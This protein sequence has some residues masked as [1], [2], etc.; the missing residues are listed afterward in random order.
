MS[1]PWDR[2]GVTPEDL[3]NWESVANSGDAFVHTAV[4]KS[5]E[6][7]LLLYVQNNRPDL[8]QN[9]QMYLET[10][11]EENSDDLKS[12]SE[13]ESLG[14][15][16]WDDDSASEDDRITVVEVG[17]KADEVGVQSVRTDEDLLVP[18]SC[19]GS[20]V[21]EWID[22]WID[23]VCHEI[24]ESCA[25]KEAQ[26]KM[27]DRFMDTPAAIV[28]TVK[29]VLNISEVTNEFCMFGTPLSSPSNSE[30]WYTNFD[31]NYQ[32]KR[33]TDASN[34]CSAEKQTL[35]PFQTDSRTFT[36]SYNEETQLLDGSSSNCER[37]IAN[38]LPEE[39]QIGF[40][41]DSTPDEIS[42]SFG[43]S[44]QNFKQK[45][46]I[47]TSNFED[48][49][50]KFNNIN[51][52]ESEFKSDESTFNNSSNEY[53]KIE[54]PL[55]VFHDLFTFEN[56]K[57]ENNTDYVPEDS[58]I[59]DSSVSIKTMVL[60]SDNLTDLDADKSNLGEFNEKSDN[61]NMWENPQSCQF[62]DS[63]KLIDNIPKPEPRIQ[64][65]MESLQ[66]T[67]AS[68][69]IF[70][71]K[72]EKFHEDFNGTENG[73]EILTISE[74]SLLESKLDDIVYMSTK[75]IENNEPIINPAILD[76]Q[77]LFKEFNN[78]SFSI[79]NGG[80]LSKK[81]DSIFPPDSHANH[82]TD[83]IAFSNLSY[84]Q[85]K[86]QDSFNDLSSKETKD[87]F[88]DFYQ[89]EN[90]FSN[91]DFE[92]KN[93]SCQILNLERRE[94]DDSQMD[95]GLDN[96][97][98]C[99]NPEIQDE[100]VESVSENSTDKADNYYE[101]VFNSL[102]SA[103]LN[104]KESFHCENLF[105]S[106]DQESNSEMIDL[107]DDSKELNTANNEFKADISDIMCY[108]RNSIPDPGG[109]EPDSE[110][111][112]QNTEEFHCSDNDM[113]Y[114]DK[115]NKNE[116]DLV[117]RSVTRISGL[118]AEALDALDDSGYVEE[119]SGSEDGNQP[120]QLLGGLVAP[121]VKENLNLSEENQPL[122]GVP[123]QNYAHD[124]TW[125]TNAES[126]IVG[127]AASSIYN[128]DTRS[129]LGNRHDNTENDGQRY[130]DRV[131]RSTPDIT[132]TLSTSEDGSRFSRALAGVL[133]YAGARST[134][135]LTK[136]GPPLAALFGK[137]VNERIRDYLNKTRQTK[138]ERNLA[139]HRRLCVS[140]A[141]VIEKAAKFEAKGHYGLQKIGM[142]ENKP[143]AAV[144][145]T[146]FRV[147]SKPPLPISSR[148]KLTNARREFFENLNVGQQPRN[149]KRFETFRE[150]TKKDRARL[151][152]STPD[153]AGFVT[154]PVRKFVDRCESCDAATQPKTNASPYRRCTGD[155]VW[156]SYTDYLHRQKRNR[157]PETNTYLETDLDTLVSR[158]VS[159]TNIDSNTKHKAISML[160]LDS[161]S[162]QPPAIEDGTRARSMDFL[163]EDDN[164]AAVLAPENT[165]SNRVKSE[166]ELRIE[167]SLQNLTVPDWYK[168]SE[169]SRK[170]KEGFLLKK[171]S[172]RH[173]WKASGSRTPSVSSLT[174]GTPRKYSTDWRNVASLRSSR[175]SL[176]TGSSCS[177]SPREQGTFHY[178]LSRWSS[179]RLSTGSVP[180]TTAS[181]QPSWNAYRSF[182]QPYLG[183]RAAATA[184]QS[185]GS[186]S[187]SPAPHS[188]LYARYSPT[189]PRLES[190][191][192]GDRRHD[193]YPANGTFFANVSEIAG[194]HDIHERPLAFCRDRY[195]YIQSVYNS[196]LSWD[197]SQHEAQDTQQQTPDTSP[198]RS[199]MV[200]MESSFVGQKSS[201][202]H[203]PPKHH[204][205][206]KEPLGS[207]VT[208][209]TDVKCTSLDEVLDSL[210][211]IP[212]S[213]RSSSP[214]TPRRDASPLIGH[215]PTAKTH[216]Y[217][218]ARTPQDLQF[219]NF[220][221]RF[222][223]PSKPASAETTHRR[224]LTDSFL[225]TAAKEESF[226]PIQI[227]ELTSS[228]SSTFRRE[229]PESERGK[230]TSQDST[231]RSGNQ[232]GQGKNPAPSPAPFLLSQSPH[233]YLNLECCSNQE[234]LPKDN[235][236]THGSFCHS[237]YW[238]P[239]VDPEGHTSNVEVLK[240]REEEDAVKG[241]SEEDDDDDQEDKI[242]NPFETMQ[243]SV[244]GT[245]KSTGT[246]KCQRPKCNKSLPV[247]EARSKFRTCPNC[248]TYYCSRQCRKLHW[249]RHQG[250][251]PQT[252]ISNL[253]K[254]V[255]MKVRDDPTSRRHLSTCARR[256]F[257]SRGRGAVKL[258]FPC[259]DDAL[260]YLCKGWDAVKA[261]TI[262]IS[263]SDL[264]AS[265][266]GS[267]I[268]SQVRTLCEKY[269]PDRKFVL[270]A[271]IMIISEGSGSP[272]GFL[273]REVVVRGTKLHLAPPLVEDDVPTLILTVI[274]EPHPTE[275]TYE[276]RLSGM[277][278][279]ENQLSDRGVI[280][281]EQFPEVY[282]KLNQFVEKNESFAP[283]NIFPTDK[284]TKKL[285]MC[286]ILP[287][288]DGDIILNIS[289]KTSRVRSK[290][291]H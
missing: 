171:E 271:A 222:S 266:I 166:R 221:E 75:T 249:A 236:V 1:V 200:W 145:P 51:T 123:P 230:V 216:I 181:S 8:L 269:N 113:L 190:S 224:P 158:E 182:R 178:G 168:Q 35:N 56:H 279:I 198:Q 262:Y 135:D 270:L 203:E 225:E 179:S 257:L 32:L 133:T 72:F 63:F 231:Q 109:K 251:C 247:D 159:E 189:S 36:L 115:S 139:H 33:N 58:E 92:S 93:E 169:W 207:K 85:D 18:P 275:T 47:E 48:P 117:P 21:E 111:K 167:R 124:R 53:D 17:S 28:N 131:A 213:S 149:D 69:D 81:D 196:E 119:S 238:K 278:S 126:P 110:W 180:S 202:Q 27:A 264:L 106:E 267:D 144:R 254:Q 41:V 259:Q 191:D 287:W 173:G 129:W 44:Y 77:D 161:P 280:L 163:L 199:K 90:I 67:N 114:V 243:E 151:A 286:I 263:R 219:P 176:P 141:S 148:V 71:L 86:T 185:P 54:V 46:E 277:R 40:T 194:H 211:A 183:W 49:K 84:S 240:Q 204:L 234:V 107:K 272:S 205:H 97:F 209:T 140:A 146:V 122:G 172:D 228:P 91:D 59:N 184:A 177:L 52:I 15:G 223:L 276:D 112:N 291:K 120:L 24:L 87:L 165:L 20:K 237:T 80:G 226:N 10:I 55:D 258:M 14:W 150:E 50:C 64:P 2:C 19:Q 108:D 9:G 68:E 76:F 78:D 121:S 283:V 65:S 160:A 73:K 260:D 74:E 218:S 252:K 60:D 128:F 153:L 164:R 34:L 255:L 285:F 214:T 11:V 282:S 268:F 188:P 241:K 197:A 57:H 22:R 239:M 265:E 66:I 31:S 89:F 147:T 187:L 79:M 116:D 138:P 157:I 186:G 233:P 193:S 37:F 127:E 162:P 42:T 152:S 88:K 26:S 45:Q 206:P 215:V 142:Q 12:I 154:A 134:P 104:H 261:Q 192:G 242:V 244:H 208:Q 105:D 70:Y 118:T 170:P 132:R 137:S 289:S 284:R 23:S 281:S 103:N 229:F 82:L 220:M 212:L 288:A 250:K 235:Q 3:F 256:G 83:E 175:E 13:E 156:S 94:V 100:N 30:F 155:I 136:V 201:G 16:S 246:I 245:T 98:V 62:I 210:L 99:L 290:K 273:D 227:R 274:K 4:D 232:D 96:K 5:D 248:Y 29:D 217:P 130:D 38:K 125:V 101:N 174:A 253:C 39:P 143:T 61:E 102:D 95:P 25:D 6:N 43:V 195:S 7:L